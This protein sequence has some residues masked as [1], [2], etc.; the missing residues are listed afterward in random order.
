MTANATSPFD[1]NK[2][3]NAVWTSG[4]SLNEIA[5]RAHLPAKALTHIVD[6][7]TGPLDIRLDT[8]KRL[9][10]HL[11][12]PLHA[13]FAAPPPPPEAASTDSNEVTDA[14]TVIATIYDRGTTPTIR[15]DL[16]LALGWDTTR[17]NAA[18]DEAEQRLAPAGLTL[19]RTHGECS[20]VPIHDHTG[21][22]TALTH[23]QSDRNGTAIAVDA[24]EAVHQVLTGQP[25]LPQ[26]KAFRRQVVLGNA[27]N[28]GILDLQPRTPRLTEA[29]TDAFPA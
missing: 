17:L 28:L 8:L 25:L 1:H 9:A 2:V 6:G 26:K 3:R 15:H 19:N 22:R 29:A 21:H 11:G 7:K 13:L 10:T 4:L 16:A 20:V 24:Y 14:T 23:A 18:L 27:A 5:Y 12:L